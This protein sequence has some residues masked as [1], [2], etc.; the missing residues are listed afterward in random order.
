MTDELD[1]LKQTNKW[2]LITL[3]AGKSVIGCKWVYKIKTKADGSVDRYKARL[4][5][6]GF[7]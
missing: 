7:T 6:K 3:L 5:S 4:V 2:D 1:A